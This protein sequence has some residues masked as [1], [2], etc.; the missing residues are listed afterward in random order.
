MKLV[1]TFIFFCTL[2]LIIYSQGGCKKNDTFSTPSIQD[3]FPLQTGKYI[4]YQ[5]DSLIYIPFST[6]DTTI[7]YLVKYEIDSLI[8]DNIGRPAYRIYRYNRRNTTQPWI[9]D[10]TFLSVAT[11][12]QIEFIEN[13][14][15][16]IKLQQPINETISWK[17]NAYIDTY[18]ANSLLKYLDNWDYSY[19]HIHE[20]CVINSVQYNDAITVNQRDEIIGNPD[21]PNS[22][23]EINFGEEKYAKGIGL[24]YK[25]FTHKEYQPGNGGYIADGSYGVTLQILDHN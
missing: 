17:G 14:L 7:S 20:S 19:S 9:P 16:F 4:T 5:L 1:R 25:K 11:N 6:R 21:D 23:S 18:S 8:T 12:F 2:L 15:R 22:Y 24:I 10:A 3:Y 13:N